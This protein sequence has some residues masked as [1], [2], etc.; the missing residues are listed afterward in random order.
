MLFSFSNAQSISITTKEYQPSQWSSRPIAVFY[1]G[2]NIQTITVQ[3]DSLL[4]KETVPFLSL[5]TLYALHIYNSLPERT[6]IEPKNLGHFLAI[7][8]G[9][10]ERTE[11]PNSQALKFNIIFLQNGVYI[12]PKMLIDN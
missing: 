12:L 7:G 9:G 2:K 4:F 6:E 1:S 5:G 11:R 8:S 3:R 10:R